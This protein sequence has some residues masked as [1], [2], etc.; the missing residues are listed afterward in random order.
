MLT[1]DNF[2]LENRVAIVTGSGRNIGRAIA[3]G[4][5]EA[6]AKVVV[7]GSRNRDAIE[8]TAE[9]IRA[10]GGEAI[11]VLADVSD[12]NAVRELVAKAVE[13]FGGVDIAVSNVSLRPYQS[14]LD[15][16]VDDWNRVI[17][18]NLSSTFYLARHTIPHMISNKKGRIIHIS[19]MDGFFGNVTHRGHNITAKAGMHGLAMSI[20]REFGAN[21]ITANTIAPGPIDT[22]RDWTQ[23]V[24]QERETVRASVPLLRYGHVDEIA[25]ACLYLSSDAGG[26]VSG[27]VIHVN[28]GHSMY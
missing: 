17:G 7:N 20:A 24:H 22:E 27:Q 9:G 10:R 5:A 16:S 26:Y 18:T 1:L 6:G 21:G 3:E 8:E 2:R 11:A 14:F 13:A 15:I 19:G 28:G 23:Y 25:A 12:D 4:F